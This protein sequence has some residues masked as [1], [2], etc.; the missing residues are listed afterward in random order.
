MPW[1]WLH[2]LHRILGLR[3]ILCLRN[4]WRAIWWR[5]RGRPRL[6]RT[7]V[8]GLAVRT[9][10]LLHRAV[11]HLVLRSSHR[12]LRSPRAVRIGLGETALPLALLPLLFLA[13]LLSPF[14]LLPLLLLLLLLLLVSGSWSALRVL[15]LPLSL[16]LTRLVDNAEVPEHQVADENLLVQRSSRIRE[17]DVTEAVY[18]ALD[19]D[20]VSR[21]H[22]ELR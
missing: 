7:T 3:R 19:V 20:G 15:S 4:G 1:L 2:K 18:G 8:G 14:P 11:L 9:I 12:R 16:V 10:A 5:W 6:G 13:F 21:I 17:L 22:P